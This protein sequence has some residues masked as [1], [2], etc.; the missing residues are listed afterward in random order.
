MR[1]L[2]R[3]LSLLVSLVGLVITSSPLADKLQGY[4]NTIPHAPVNG[5]YSFH[6]SQRQ[7]TRK[8]RASVSRKQSR[9]RQSQ[10]VRPDIFSAIESHSI[11]EVNYLLNTDPSLVRLVRD[12]ETPLMLAVE[13]QQLEIIALLLK[14]HANVN[15]R[16]KY[17]RTP[18][19]VAVEMDNIDLVTLLIKNRAN[20]NATNN[21]DETPL[22]IAVTSSQET[23]VEILLENGADVNAKDRFRNTPVDLASIR[24]DRSILRRVIDKGAVNPTYRKSDV[25]ST[26]IR[27]VMTE[28]GTDLLTAVLNRDE[29]AVSRLLTGYT[30]I[31]ATDQ[32]GLTPLMHSIIAKSAKITELLLVKG[33]DVNIQS[34]DGHTALL[35]AISNAAQDSP[36]YPPLHLSQRES[37]IRQQ[38]SMIKLIKVLLQGDADPNAQNKHGQTGLMIAARADSV[39]IVSLLLTHNADVRIKDE[40]GRNVLMYAVE[41]KDLPSCLKLLLD[42]KI[43]I[44]DHDR[45]GVTALMMAASWGKLE[46]VRHLIHK[47][48]NVN[49]I[50]NSGATALGL[51]KARNFTKI[52]EALR[53]AGAEH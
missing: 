47:G 39:E 24:G 38:E 5:S 34:K 29:N 31:D 32:D 3:F 22:H 46:T 30:D 2:R 41:T 21:D 17:G 51:A 12:E 26:E 16:G 1:T 27:T 20:V 48:A 23:L 42:S 53:A 11:E 9:S 4:A 19:H 33:A 8:G 28:R 25:A 7:N 49:A 44:N 43:N 6:N 45:E 40:D 37:A 18:L 35:L 14:H 10:R 15:V 50:S 13:S 36:K 52:I